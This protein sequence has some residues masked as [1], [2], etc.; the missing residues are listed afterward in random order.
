MSL[1]VLWQQ[2]PNLIWPQNETR[3]R[4]KNGNDNAFLL[5]LPPAARIQFRGT[6]TNT[7]KS[8]LHFL[9][10]PKLPL[11]MNCANLVEAHTHTHHA[12]KANQV[13]LHRVRKQQEQLLD[14]W[15]LLNSGRFSAPLL[16]PRRIN[17]G[18]DGIMTGVGYKGL[19]LLPKPSSSY[20]C[21]AWVSLSKE[22]ED[23]LF[24]LRSLH[25][26]QEN[27][28]RPHQIE[29]VAKGAAAA[30]S[31]SSRSYFSLLQTRMTEIAR[32]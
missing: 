3:G 31:P 17:F 8:H 4:H 20:T 12:E 1:A 15:V 2:H 22:G 18:L 21:S 27:T 14:L 23:N 28:R 26:S 16:F 19:L 30:R 25:S 29:P 9:P 7:H 6:H 32:C 24:L 5:F 11:L 10:P 13:L